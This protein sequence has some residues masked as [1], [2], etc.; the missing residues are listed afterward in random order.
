MPQT[1]AK[2]KKSLYGVHPGVA[3]VQK[4]IDDLPEKTGKSFEQWLAY[5][6]K[7]GPDDDTACVQWL[8]SEHG[9]GSN[10][11]SWLAGRA[12]NKPMGLADDSPESYLKLAPKYVDDMFAGAKAALRPLY[13]KLLDVCLNFADDVKACP[14][15]TIVPIYRNHVIAQIKPTTQTRIDFGLALKDTKTPS[16]LINTGGFAKKDRITHRIPVT[17]LK[18]IDAELVKWLK[19]A[20]DMDA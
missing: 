16:R 19:K 4:W 3:M 20:Y 1:A 12:A 6:R 5:I 17:S 15:Q 7:N 18:D 2:K 14:C 11:A 10:T 13:D 9:F 8:K